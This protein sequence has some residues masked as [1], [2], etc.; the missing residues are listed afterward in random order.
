[1][2]IHS[3]Y[4]VVTFP[5]INY[6]TD[7]PLTPKFLI[8]HCIGLPL[9]DVIEGFST[10]RSDQHPKGL[11]V[12][13]HYFIPQLTGK[14]LQDLNI[15]DTTHSLNY[16]LEVPVLQ[17]V[18]ESHQAFHAGESCWKGESN[19]NKTSIG[20]E[21]HAPGF[22]DQDNWFQFT[23]YT[24]NQLKTGELLL[25]DIIQKWKISSNN[26]LAHS[27]ISPYRPLATPPAPFLK[28]D[29]GPL[30]PWKQFA[31]DGIGYMPQINNES[32]D[33]EA[34]SQDKEKY[35]REQLQKIG[36]YIPESDP[37]GIHDRLVINAYRMH[38]MQD[39][40][41]QIAIDSPDFGYIDG[42]LLNSLKSWSLE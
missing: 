34:N 19:L 16:P 32:D 24:K 1:M 36:Y 21:F 25:R 14:E 15:I 42:T 29:P 8:V 6:R 7:P 13:A 33:F 35:V 28:T 40:Y 39:S 11:G 38:Y 30:F 23:P 37:W 10:S 17:F 41:Q 31:L 9:Q 26:I 4:D 18:P 22:G 27:D 2:S 12:S 20:I 3:G 5:S